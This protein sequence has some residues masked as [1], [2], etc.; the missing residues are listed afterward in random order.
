MTI[1][2]LQIWPCILGVNDL[3]LFLCGRLASYILIVDDK[4]W[5]VSFWTQVSM[6]ICIVAPT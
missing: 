4:V 5:I 3:K 1:V 6:D 2:L